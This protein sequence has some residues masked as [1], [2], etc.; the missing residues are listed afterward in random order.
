MGEPKKTSTDRTSFGL[1]CF[2]G[3]D[4]EE[5]ETDPCRVTVYTSAEQWQVW[6]CHS[7]CFRER[8]TD[9]PDAPG[10]FEPAHF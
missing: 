9:P 1:C 6:F 8:L 2:C 4:I 5:S 7:V 10:L 3:L